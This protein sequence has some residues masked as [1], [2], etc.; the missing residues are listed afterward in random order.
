MITDMKALGQNGLKPETVSK[1][2]LK[3]VQDKKPKIR[4]TFISELTFN[5]MYLAPRRLMDKLVTRYL[6]LESTARK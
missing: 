4:Y 6:G 5:I 1:K 3:A 2:I